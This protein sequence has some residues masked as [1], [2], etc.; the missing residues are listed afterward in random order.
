MVV[1]SNWISKPVTD[2]KFS[3][4]VNDLAVYDIK[5]G[6]WIA[7]GS[8]R[9]LWQGLDW[10]GEDIDIF[11]NNRTQIEQ[12]HNHIKYKFIKS[13][14]DLLDEYIQPTNLKKDTD[15]DVYET[16]NAVSYTLNNPSEFGE[17]VKIQ[18]IRRQFY[19]SAEDLLN[20]FDWTVCQFV[21]D[22]TTMWAT[23]LAER[24]LA[25]KNIVLSPTTTRTV[26]TLRL[27]KYSAYG[28]NASD[29]MMIAALSGIESGN[30]SQDTED[31][32]A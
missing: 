13:K 6:P 8:V 32:Y 5:Q 10:S 9:K 16:S 27:M 20:D 14:F 24:D 4:L 26:K 2:Q 11:F 3:K 18:A 29:E 25:A 1:N 15:I 19:D 22:G 30:A 21:S 12:F 17:A 7:G 23:P 28:F 31:D